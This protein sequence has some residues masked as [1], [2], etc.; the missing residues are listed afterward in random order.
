MKCHIENAKEQLTQV[1]Y[2]GIHVLGLDNTLNNLVWDRFTCF[3]V[4]ANV[5]ERLGVVAPVFQHLKNIKTIWPDLMIVNF[6]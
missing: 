6:T 2:G 3:K 4:S 5:F 1:L